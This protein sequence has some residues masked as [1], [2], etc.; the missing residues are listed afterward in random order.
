MSEKML[1]K[2]GKGLLTGALLCSLTAQTVA[3][4]A[5]SGGED[6][7]YPEKTHQEISLDDM[8]RKSF[9]ADAFSETVEELLNLCEKSGQE[10]RVTELYESLKTQVD[11]LLTMS[12]LANLDYYSN[13]EDQEAADWNAQVEE[14][15]RVAADQASV[16]LRE[17]LN[18]EYGDICRADMD[19][20]NEASYLAYVDMTE[21]EEALYNQH[22]ELIAEYEEKLMDSYDSDEE[23]NQVLGEIFREM[24]QLRTQI[25]QAAGCESYA[26]YTYESGYFRDYSLEDV[27]SLR[28][29]VKEELVDFYYDLVN[30]AIDG[31]VN[32][33]FED[34]EVSDQ[35]LLETLA[36][37]MEKVNPEIGETFS[38]FMDHQLY[39]LENDDS[40]INMAYTTS[41]PSYGAAYIYDN[42]YDSYQD[43]FTLIH[44]FG[45]FNSIYHDDTPELYT[46]ANMDVSEIH[47]QGLELLFYPY[48]EEMYPGMGEAMQY[49]VLYEM[50]VNIL[51]SCAYDEFET[52]VYADPDM[53]LEEMN[54]AMDSIVEDYGLDSVYADSWVETTQLFSQPSYMISYATSALAALELF[55]LA[56]SDRDL[57]IDTYMKISAQAT[58]QPFCQVLEENGLTDIFDLDS[59]ETLVEDLQRTLW[60]QQQNQ[61]GQDQDSQGDG[62]SFEESLQ[63]LEQ[64][65]WEELT[66]TKEETCQE[67]GW[68]ILGSLVA[69]GLLAAVLSLVLGRKKE[70][71]GNRMQ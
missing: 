23:E 47:S 24:V 5:V 62:E 71:P 54:Q 49:Y 37:Y 34:Y 64:A 2:L 61:R 66:G 21:E 67:I 36:P 44:E 46:N 26:E 57:A 43:V 59:V 33:V 48:Y 69:A 9:D 45:H 8:D 22:Q 19:D 55:C 1:G 14:I 68:V 12:A 52:E 20:Y 27:A 38:Y 63:E 30:Q 31:G 15:Y 51:V 39:D 10:E 13:M 16:C 41:L 58:S 50:V 25:A 65:I 53:T 7:Y 42:R 3:A 6:S 18:S 56:D 70:E 28:D 11:Q 32:D 40:K 29:E 4:A 17:M 35:E 60:Y